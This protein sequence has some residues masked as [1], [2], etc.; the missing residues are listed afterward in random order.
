MKT[1]LSILALAFLLGSCT[2]N[3]VT[4][5][6][7]LKQYFDGSGVTGTFGMFDNGQG[8]FTIYNLRR[9]RDSAYLPAA[10]FDI[11]QSLVGIQTGVVN[12]DSSLIGDLSRSW[13]DSAL[14]KASHLPTDS[15]L[16]RAPVMMLSQAFRLSC[17]KAFQ[18]LSQR[19]GK[20]T[21]KKWIDSLSYGNKD[22]SSAVDTF[23]L[24]NHLTITADEQL[25]LIKRLYFD[26]LPFF[27]RSQKLVREMMLRESNSNY[28]LSYKMGT[29]IRKDGHVLTW[30]TG[31]VEENKHPYFFVLNLDAADFTKDLN[32]S[33][34][35]ILKDILKQMG[36]FQGKK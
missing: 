17:T 15:E 13:T 22:I 28:Q 21:L 27:V 4:E 36:F 3:N 26:Q 7:S 14:M 29:G 19:I 18:G 25:G 32:F 1:F 8:H 5:D 12:N 10:T 16:C 31:W 20:D 9:F 2:Q 11:L 23:W 6:D 34:L 33:G 35:N 24:D 30:I